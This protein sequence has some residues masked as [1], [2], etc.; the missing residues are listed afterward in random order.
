[1]QAEIIFK[2]PPLGNRPVGHPAGG[3]PE[4]LVV[5]A[6]VASW[7]GEPQ[8]HVSP[9]LLLLL[10]LLLPRGEFLKMTSVGIPTYAGV[11]T[12]F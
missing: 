2:N 5:P 6:V 4:E 9:G 1:M 11:K 8:D 12:S 10:L 3:A 7:P